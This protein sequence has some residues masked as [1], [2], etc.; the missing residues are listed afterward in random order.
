MFSSSFF[1]YYQLCLLIVIDVRSNE[2][3]EC[4]YRLHLFEQTHTA[5]SD[6]THAHKSHVVDVFEIHCVDVDVKK[7][8]NNDKVEEDE[9]FCYDSD[10]VSTTM[11][12]TMRYVNTSTTK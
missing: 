3:C 11:S 2:M 10:A 4:A 12:N 1:S 5:T 8:E 7:E 6:H 9:I